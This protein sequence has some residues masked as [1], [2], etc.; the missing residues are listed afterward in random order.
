MYIQVYDILIVIN[1]AYQF[2]FF[3][4]MRLDNFWIIINIRGLH[5]RVGNVCSPDICS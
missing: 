2:D 1:F 4:G 3:L 5:V